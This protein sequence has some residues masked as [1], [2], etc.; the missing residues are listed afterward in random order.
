MDDN[1]RGL[2]GRDLDCSYDD[3]FSMMR[4]LKQD[5]LPTVNMDCV[6][7]GHYERELTDICEYVADEVRA[8]I[9]EAFSLITEHN[10]KCTKHVL[11]KRQ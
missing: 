7:K 11:G 8:N 2:I 10:V 5:Q 1:V 6:S 9:E 4:E 3:I